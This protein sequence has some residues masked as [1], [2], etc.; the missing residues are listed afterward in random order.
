MG[1]NN[2]GFITVYDRKT[3]GLLRDNYAITENYK[4]LRQDAH[5]SWAEVQERGELLVRVG[6]NDLEV[7]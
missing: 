7:Y 5:G 1:I 4:L 2:I 3:G 6:D